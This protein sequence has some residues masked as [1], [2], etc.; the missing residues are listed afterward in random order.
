MAYDTSFVGDGKY[1]GGK[2]GTK[3]Y[4]YV[5]ADSAATIAGAGYVANAASP[6]DQNHNMSIG[7]LV[8]VVQVDDPAAVTSAAG[9]AV[10]VVSDIDAAGAGTLIKTDTA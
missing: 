1:L 10:Y 4:S 7:D 8:K 6:A 5:T 2:G 9:L 3:E